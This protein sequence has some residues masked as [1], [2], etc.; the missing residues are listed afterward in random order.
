[1]KNNPSMFQKFLW[2]IS[3]VEVWLLKECPTSFKYYSRQGLLF[4]MTFFFAAF[5]GAFAGYDFGS[6]LITI[7]SFG[8]IW[9]LLVYSIDQMMIQTID[10]IQVSKQSSKIKFWK[11]F[12]PR[13]LLGCL[14]ALFMSSPLD[15]FIFHDQIENQMQKN[16]DNTWISYQNELKSSIDLVGTRE[17]QKEALAKEQELESRK[18]LTPDSY[19]YTEAKQSLEIANK[20]LTNLKSVKDK[21]L[22]NRKHA[23]EMVPSKLDTLT[24]KKVKIRQSAEYSAY[25]KRY[26]AHESSKSNY[27]L[28]EKEVESYENTI[29]D[30]KIKYEKELNLKIKQNDTIVS[31]LSSKIAKDHIAIENKTEEKQKFLSKMNGFDTKFMTLLTHPNFG[32]QFLR[33]FIFLVFLLI[34][35]IP[36]WMKLMGSP[37]EYDDKLNSIKNKR[38]KDFTQSHTNDEALA[39]IRQLNE[40]DITKEKEVQRKKMELKLHKKTLKSL[41][42]KYEN[43]TDGILQEWEDK[44]KTDN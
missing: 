30:E 38:I 26:R 2:N 12:F 11:Y 32:V 21:A 18:K 36:T 7:I 10:K 23:W 27:S 9:G 31:S 44:L 33:W 22:L 34:E 37:T 3:G 35:I 15:H 29:N 39:N 25:L 6:S 20:E 14:L 24:N 8:F 19:V 28:K 43:I 40:I 41:I 16:A 17:R 42:L 13:L 1:M 4:L 5:C